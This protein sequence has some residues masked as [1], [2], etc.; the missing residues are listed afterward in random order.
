MG[1]GEVNLR[2]HR[3]IKDTIFL[4]PQHYDDIEKE[5][6]TQTGGSWKVLQRRHVLS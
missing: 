5:S 3:V 1:K 6:L 4:C 2:I